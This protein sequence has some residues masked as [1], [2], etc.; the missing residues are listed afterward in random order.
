LLLSQAKLHLIE[1]TRRLHEVEEAKV[2]QAI[3]QSQAL[4]NQ[5]KRLALE[6]QDEVERWLKLQLAAQ[7][8]GVFSKAPRASAKRAFYA[9]APPPAPSQAAE[10]EE[11]LPLAELIRPPAAVSAAEPQARTTAPGR[12]ATSAHMPVTVVSDVVPHPLRVD[13]DD[14]GA[15]A[16]QV[17]SLDIRVTIV[18]QQGAS[19]HASIKH[20]EEGAVVPDFIQYCLTKEMLRAADTEVSGL[21]VLSVE[22]NGDW[23]EYKVADGR[24]L[25]YNRVKREAHLS[26]ANEEIDGV[27]VRV[28]AQRLIAG[29][30]RYARKNALLLEG[31]HIEEVRRQVAERQPAP[32]ILPTSTKESHKTHAGAE[33]EV[34]PDVPDMKSAAA[35]SAR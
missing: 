18:E 28:K 34:R 2:A 24:S 16:W 29:D 26:K 1:A 25:F 12:R 6:K 4:I 13:A 33:L 21:S 3:R 23:I 22:D 15:L 14:P 32:V 11:A 19:Q 9:S 30:R 27:S 10:A 7:G 5:R 35:A 31:M 20:V 8:A 17:D